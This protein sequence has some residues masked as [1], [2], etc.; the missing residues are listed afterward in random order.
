MASAFSPPV[1]APLA[2]KPKLSVLGHS[3][4]HC[5]MAAYGEVAAD[6]DRPFD[7]AFLNM[8]K[9]NHLIGVDG[10]WQ[11]H[12]E[13]VAQA[14]D[15]IES[16][17]ADAIVLMLQGEQATLAGVNPPVRAFE[18]L[19]PEEAAAEVPAGREIVPYDLI[20]KIDEQ[21]FEPMVA[22]LSQVRPGIA[23]P[24]VA[25]AP[26]PPVGDTDFVV[27]CLAVAQPAPAEIPE[28]RW[29]YRRWRVA[30]SVMRQLYE[31]H[32][33]RFFAP[34]P[35]AADDDGCLRSEYYWDAVHANP[36][37]GHLL[38]AQLREFVGEMK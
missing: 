26:P 31:A 22:F 23:A 21:S 32:A 9:E 15:F 11:Y 13:I 10:K 33:A 28:T 14:V 8:H 2:R 3:H 35:A 17:A 27:K 5:L 16:S 7:L 37:Y 1:A 4:M 18:F 25:L 19:F 38:L 6:D 20:R 29:R 30:V 24:V 12:P 34:P 36:K